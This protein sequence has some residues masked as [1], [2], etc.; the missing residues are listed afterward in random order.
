MLICTYKTK[1]EKKEKTHKILENRISYRR[2]ILE[3][4]EASIR[5]QFVPPFLFSISP[6]T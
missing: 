1:R 3:E 2:K 5:S 6:F 4:G